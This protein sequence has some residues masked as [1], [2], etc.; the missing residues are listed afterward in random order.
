MKRGAKNTWVQLAGAGL[1]LPL[2]AC[3]LSDSYLVPAKAIELVSSQ[4]PASR[5]RAQLPAL[6]EKEQ[7]P[8]LIRY[9]ALNWDDESLRLATSTPMQFARVRAAKTN[10]LL[11]AGGVI[12]ALGVP[13][14]VV[15]TM[16]A[17]DVPKGEVKTADPWGVGVGMGLGGLHF[18]VGGLLMV[19]GERNPN[20]EP[21][22]PGLVQAYLYGQ[23]PTAT[24]APDAITPTGEAAP[25]VRPSRQETRD[26]PVGQDNDKK[27][28]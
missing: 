18:L 16:A 4:P 14:F 12:L 26:V 1:L 20:I 9:R 19:L 10:P 24:I 7:T 8:V 21:T 15:G 27:D 28:D 6:H 3:S 17:L 2:C 11:I 13:H 23:I 25:P 22:E 5:Q